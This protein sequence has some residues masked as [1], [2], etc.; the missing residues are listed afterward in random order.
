MT[1]TVLFNTNSI[2]AAMEYYRLVVNRRMSTHPC[3]IVLYYCRSSLRSPS[4]CW[5]CY[6]TVRQ[7]L[8]RFGVTLLLVIVYQG[9]HC[10]LCGRGLSLY[11]CRFWCRR[12]KTFRM[13]SA[14]L[15]PIVHS[16]YQLGVLFHIS[17]HMLTFQ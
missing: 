8:L 12:R 11:V 15:Q 13:S 9:R 10:Y 2:C 1:L 5:F 4:C 6:I 7:V 3:V 16:L 14:S 17:L